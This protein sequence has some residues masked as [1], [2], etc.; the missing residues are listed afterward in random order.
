MKH[1]PKTLFSKKRND[2]MDQ[3][4]VA[5]ALAFEKALS[6]LEAEAHESDDPNYIIT[7]AL[8]SACEFYGADWSGFLDVDLD[9]R[10]WTPFMWYNPGIY[11]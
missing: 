3:E 7:R 6:S 5:Y 11:A 4:H 1:S 8:K 9:L 2:K 10:L